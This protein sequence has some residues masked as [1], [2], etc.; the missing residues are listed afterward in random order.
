MRCRGL[1]FGYD[2]LVIAV[3]GQFLDAFH[4]DLVSRCSLDLHLQ[5]YLFIGIFAKPGKGH[6]ATR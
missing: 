4:N 1:V 6:V 5:V 2:G 3:K